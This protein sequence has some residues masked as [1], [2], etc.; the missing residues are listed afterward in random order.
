MFPSIFCSLTMSFDITDE[1]FNAVWMLYVILCLRL[2]CCVGTNVSDFMV[3]TTRKE[4]PLYSRSDYAL[5]LSSLK[6]VVG[7]LFLP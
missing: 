7:I 2:Y 4:L 6:P 5:F 3:F 1:F